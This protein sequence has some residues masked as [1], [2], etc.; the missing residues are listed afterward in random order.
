MI[1]IFTTI[2]ATCLFFQS[3][4]AQIQ[5]EISD[6]HVF[7]NKYYR[8]FVFN[9][10]TQVEIT[11]PGPNQFWDYFLLN[12][13]FQD[14]LT[15]VKADLTPFYSSFPESEF[16]ITTNNLSFFYE[17]LAG[18]GATIQGRAVYDPITNTQVITPFETN[19]ISLPYP[20]NY[21]DSYSFGYRYFTVN[22][23]FLPNADSSRSNTYADISIS[24]DASGMLSIPGGTF[25]V[26]RFRQTS[27]KID[28]VYLWN[29]SDG[30][31]FSNVFYDTTITDLFYTKNI[32]SSLL[33]ITTR[34]Q[35]GIIA[36]NYLKGFVINGTENAILPKIQVFPQPAS[37]EVWVNSEQDLSAQLIDLHGRKHKDLF[38]PKGNT[39]IERLNLPSGIYFLRCFDRK[40]NAAGVKK[41]VFAE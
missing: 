22:S 3:G 19:G 25:D 21:G 10:F 41:L 36:I 2:A 15:I 39:S 33:T 18:E 31:N 9:D 17:S 14:T 37:A 29:L 16:A 8:G 38:L 24:V 11:P 23:S 30:W 4:F 32:G 40:G 1:R 5:L 6:Y 27:T 20:I 28:S 13:D 26:L 7:D 12:E 34:P 35:S